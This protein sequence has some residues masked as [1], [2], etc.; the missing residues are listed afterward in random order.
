MVVFRQTFVRKGLVMVEVISPEAALYIWGPQTALFQ[1]YR[2]YFANRID[3]TTRKPIPEPITDLG[4]ALVLLYE[5]D[6]TQS[7]I[8]LDG[9]LPD[10]TQGPVIEIS[11]FNGGYGK[12]ELSEQWNFP[13][14]REL[15]ESL[16][17]AGVLSGTPHM[18]YTDHRELRLNERAT[19]L[20]YEEI[21][22]Y[23]EAHP[24]PAETA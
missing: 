6:K 3:R 17:A 23:D 2:N 5:R 7:R 8:R 16:K 1:R 21:K 10:G 22:K 9:D 24:E 14:A 19:D 18:G 15:V 20:I 11:V 13:I 4:E 12:C